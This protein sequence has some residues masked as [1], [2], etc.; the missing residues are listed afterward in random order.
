M[1][2]P[3]KLR[4]HGAAAAVDQEW[5]E[6]MAA[7]I[8]SLDKQHLVMVGTWGYFGASTPQLLQENIYDL[9]WRSSGDDSG[10]WSAGKGPFWSDSLRKP[11]VAGLAVC[12][13]QRCRAGVP[14]QL[15]FE[16]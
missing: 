13:V 4:S 1:H 12:G 11:T 8:K 9:T 2:F 7:Y 5:V 15:R 6:D 16:Q 3:E 14:L 10:I